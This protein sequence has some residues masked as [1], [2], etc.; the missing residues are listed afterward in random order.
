M[1]AACSVIRLHWCF[2]AL[3][4]VFLWFP[5]AA[6]SCNA[7]THAFISPTTF[8]HRKAFEGRRGLYASP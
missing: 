8:A 1:A 7:G 3:F 5:S 2:L 4:H 6:D